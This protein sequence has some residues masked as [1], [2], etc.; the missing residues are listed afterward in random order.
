[1]DLPTLLGSGFGIRSW[2]LELGPGAGTWSC[3]VWV[4]GSGHWV[5]S[6]GG[7]EVGEVIV[8]GG[9]WTNMVTLG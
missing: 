9:I 8:R 2:D 3:R 4:A 1:M 6:V 5:W 7:F